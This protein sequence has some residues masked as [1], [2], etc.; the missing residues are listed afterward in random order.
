MRNLLIIHF[1]SVLCFFS[2][3]KSHSICVD[4]ERF[5]SVSNSD[6]FR[7]TIED[8]NNK[9]IDTIYWHGNKIECE[10]DKRL[11][12]IL[13]FIE[14]SKLD[15]TGTID[16]QLFRSVIATDGNRT[17]ICVKED[18]SIHLSGSKSNENITRLWYKEMAKTK[19]EDVDNY[20]SLNKFLQEE[21][22]DHSTDLYGAY[23][24]SLDYV[25]LRLFY[26]CDKELSLGLNASVLI[27][28]IESSNSFLS[29]HNVARP[30]LEAVQNAGDISPTLIFDF[31]SYMI[32]LNI[33]NKPQIS[34]I[35]TIPLKIS[36]EEFNPY[37]PIITIESNDY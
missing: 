21:I 9:A 26:A 20:C 11:H 10:I 2:C 33:T 5:D 25:L 36:D 34:P 19:I 32:P 16:R 13:A 37:A 31:I 6:S 24:Q 30:F 7:M 4:M 28:E 8:P 3:S 18:G 12:N 1:L 29:N 22:K 15:S 23:I 35:D 17:T 27:Y 14:V